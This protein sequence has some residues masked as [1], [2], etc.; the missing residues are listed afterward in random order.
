MAKNSPKPDAHALKFLGKLGAKERLLDE[1]KVPQEKFLRGSDLKGTR[2]GDDISSNFPAEVAILASTMRA[3]EGRIQ[4][5]ESGE[6]I[7]SA[8]RVFSEAVDTQIKAWD[9][10]QETE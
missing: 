5:G 10:L 9:V 7:T 2:L 1:L 8:L 6:E 4:A 3:L